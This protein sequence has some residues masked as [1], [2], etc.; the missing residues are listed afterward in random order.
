MESYHK[1]K[2]SLEEKYDKLINSKPFNDDNGIVDNTQ[3]KYIK[4]VT[5]ISDEEG[6]RL[7]YE[8]TY[9]SYQH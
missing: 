6:L 4:Q 9:G 5:G 7:A 1:G 3:H 8:A 2:K